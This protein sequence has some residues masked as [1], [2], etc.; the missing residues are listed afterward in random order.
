MLWYQSAGFLRLQGTVSA[1]SGTTQRNAFR[2]VERGGLDL[3]FFF[4]YE[5]AWRV[6]KDPPYP[7]GCTA[8]PRRVYLRDLDAC[9][10][11]ARAAANIGQRVGNQRGARVAVGRVRSPESLRQRHGAAANPASQSRMAPDLAHRAE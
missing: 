7:G 9:V 11:E 4:N 1:V 10:V 2:R 5:R 8:L 6:Q 3:I